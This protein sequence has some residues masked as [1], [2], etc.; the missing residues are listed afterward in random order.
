VR[1]TKTDSDFASYASQTQVTGNKIR[2][3]RTYQVNQ[4]LIP[5]DKLDE[6]RKFNRQ[7]AADE[8][9]SVVLKR[10]AQ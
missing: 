2:Y 8:R 1:P 6:L 10:G 4:V 3:K 7:V 9:S 5:L